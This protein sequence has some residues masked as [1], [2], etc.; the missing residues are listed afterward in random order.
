M[1]FK[2][3]KML[4]YQATL[5]MPQHQE[6]SILYQ[7]RKTGRLKWQAQ[8]GYNRR[9]L[10]ETAMFRYKTIIGA[11]LRSRN[12]E[13]QKTEAK[14]GVTVINKMTNLGMPISVRA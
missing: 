11:H 9:S 3:E 5:L 12:F 10:V 14:I 2:N 13:S 6:I 4:Y 7:S 8:T 1:G